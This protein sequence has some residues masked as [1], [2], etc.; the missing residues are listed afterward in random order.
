[1]TS[2]IAFIDI[3]SAFKYA[4]ENYTRNI[5]IS[6]AEQFISQTQL[7]TPFMQ[8]F[9]SLLIFEGY[10]IIDEDTLFENKDYFH[11]YFSKIK[12]DMISETDVSESIDRL[13]PSLIQNSRTVL[14]K[15][16]KDMLVSFEGKHYGG[17]NWSFDRF[18]IYDTKAD[19]IADYTDEGYILMINSIV[20]HTKEEVVAM[21]YKNINQLEALLS[22]K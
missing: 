16:Y 11:N 19:L 6:H 18:K 13:I 17:P 14:F 8:R 9:K 3:D 5:N 22:S 15:K 1:M 2:N 7:L 4:L 10:H 12:S 21:A 20:S